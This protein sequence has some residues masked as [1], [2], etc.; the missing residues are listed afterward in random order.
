MNI[1]FRDKLRPETEWLG[2]AIVTLARALAD[3][4]AADYDRAACTL[5]GDC[6]DDP[7]RVVW[8]VLLGNGTRGHE[9]KATVHQDPCEPVHFLHLDTGATWTVEHAGADRTPRAR[10][11]NSAH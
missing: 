2:P 11:G 6:W 8:R 7:R 4:G 3:E 1:I 10:L 9:W 5:L